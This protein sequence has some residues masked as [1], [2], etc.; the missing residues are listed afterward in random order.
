MALTSTQIGNIPPTAMRSIAFYRLGY[1]TLPSPMTLESFA[2][3]LVGASGPWEEVLRR[4]LF[5][6]LE[7]PN[8]DG[9]RTVI[10]DDD[11][12]SLTDQEMCENACSDAGVTY[13]NYADNDARYRACCEVWFG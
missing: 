10:C 7:P 9:P 12:T 11:T 8:R 2:T 6:F 13:E 5:P 4:L 3:A 1:G